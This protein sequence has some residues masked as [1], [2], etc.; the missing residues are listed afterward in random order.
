LSGCHYP[1]IILR[2]ANPAML[3]NA[4]FTK[5]SSRI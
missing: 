2:N 5:T 3:R 1:P 4:F